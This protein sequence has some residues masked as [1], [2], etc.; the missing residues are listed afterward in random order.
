MTRK[1]R[2]SMLFMDFH[3]FRL[4]NR[5][6]QV[7]SRCPSISLHVKLAFLPKQ[8]V[9]RGVGGVKGRLAVCS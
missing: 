9:L 4:G 8:V 2:V 7:S 1:C 5:P 3:G 6:F